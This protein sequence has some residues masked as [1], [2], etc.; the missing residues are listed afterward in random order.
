MASKFPRACDASDSPTVDRPESPAHPAQ[1][2]ED[3]GFGE[4]IL[5]RLR[6]AFCALH[7]HDNLLQF[8]HERMFLKCAS[9]GHESPG[10]ELNET[11]PTVVAGVDRHPQPMVRPNFVGA[12][13]IA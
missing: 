10:W 4:R 11:P 2:H 13:R 9:C 1:L 8:Q 6:E 5:D 7:G 12:R 3:E